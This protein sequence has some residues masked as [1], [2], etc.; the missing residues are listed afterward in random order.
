MGGSRG[1]GHVWWT[2]GK[3]A[4]DPPPPPANKNIPRTPQLPS[5][6]VWIRACPFLVLLCVKKLTRKHTRDALLYDA[7]IESNIALWLHNCLHPPY[8]VKGDHSL[9]KLINMISHKI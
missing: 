1:V 8:T 5:K 9:T 2:P 6:K 4:T 7:T 3:Y